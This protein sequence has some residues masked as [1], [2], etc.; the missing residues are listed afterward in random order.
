MKRPP[1]PILMTRRTFV[2]TPA[3]L[4]LASTLNPLFGNSPETEADAFACLFNGHD[5]TGWH[6][7]RRPSAHG[8]GG[9]WQVADGVL[10][11]EQDPP[12]SGNGGLLLTDEKFA[13]FELSIDM[14]PDWGPDSGV[15]FRCTEEGAGFQM[16]VDYHDKGNVGHLRGEM[17]GS[18]ALKP[19][20]FFGELDQAER[21]TGFSTK[22]DSRA[23]KWPPGVYEYTCTA[24]QWLNTWRVGQWNNARIRCVGKHPKITTWINGLKVCHF[25]GQ[26][27]THPGYDKKR[28]F[29]ILGRAGSIGLQVHGGKAWPNGTKCRWRNIRIKKL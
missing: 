7:N 24:Q 15:F 2:L 28:V 22:P 29:G 10:T 1:C 18:F 20:Q 13:D 14:H 3:A 25:D 4:S 8:T 19:F 16:Y 17:P 27:C 9:L 26:T 11:G 5:S 23:E 21:L 6:K 12:G